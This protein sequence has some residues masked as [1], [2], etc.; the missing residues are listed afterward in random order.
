MIRNFLQF[1]I[2]FICLFMTIGCNRGVETDGEAR[3]RVAFVMKTLNNP[4][5]VRM[6]QGARDAAEEAGIELLVQAPDREIDVERQMQIVENLLQTGIQVLCITPSGSREILPAIQK[7]NAAGVPV[8]VVDTRLDDEAAKEMGVEYVAFIGSDNYEGGRL[9][10]QYFVRRFHEP[11]QVAVLEGIPGHETADSR[12]NG[13]L[14]AVQGVTNIQ[15]AVSQTANS[16]RDQ[17]FNVMQNMLQTYPGLRG[18]FACNDMMALGAVEAI[19][20]ANKT[21]QVAVI[22]FDAVPEA[23]D[24]IREGRMAASVAQFPDEMGKVA[25]QTAAAILAGQPVDKN[26]PVHIELITKE[27]VD[28]VE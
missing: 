3:P 7:A 24:A 2:G 1:F 21:N 9:A 23:R 10:G 18:L 13:F 6:H 27:N 4:F 5:F 28:T 14:D 11:A 8:L 12:K 15:V 25:I 17:G 26:I 16:E 19:A 20:A 22:G